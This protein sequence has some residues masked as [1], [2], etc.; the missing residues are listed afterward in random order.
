MPGDGMDLGPDD[1][2]ERRKR[3]AQCLVVHLFRQVADVQP[4]GGVLGLL[5]HPHGPLVLLLPAPQCLS[6]SVLQLVDPNLPPFPS[7]LLHEAS[8][9][10]VSMK[11]NGATP[12]LIACN[13]A[14]ENVIQ[15]AP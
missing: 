10:N 14:R 12:N 15:C 1:L 13:P 8:N 2:P 6:A 11:L 7:T 4:P 5:G 9:P 3:L